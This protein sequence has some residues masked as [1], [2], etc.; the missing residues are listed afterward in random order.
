MK[1][2]RKVSEKVS[3]FDIP[4]GDCFTFGGSIFM[5]VG[6]DN[7]ELDCPECNCELDADD[8]FCN[9]DISYLAVELCSGELCQF[10]YEEG[11]VPIKM[12]AVEV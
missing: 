10:T 12:K 3:V 4:I 7:L 1:I 2:E 9:T 6:Y 5:R 11:V 8:L